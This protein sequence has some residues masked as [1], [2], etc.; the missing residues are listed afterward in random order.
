MII[1]PRKWLTWATFPD[2]SDLRWRFNWIYLQAACDKFLLLYVRQ[3]FTTKVVNLRLSPESIADSM[4]A[5]AR[6]QVR[7]ARKDALTISYHQDI[8]III[9]LFNLTA[10]AKGLIGVSK[11]TFTTK[12]R[13]LVSQIDAE[14]T[15]PLAAHF[16]LLDESGKRVYLSYN[17]SAYRKFSG[18]RLRSLCGRAN[19]LLFLED[20]YYFKSLGY[21]AYDF[22]GYDPDSTDPSRQ[23]VNIFKDDLPGEVVMQYNYYPLWY[24]LFKRAYNQIQKWRN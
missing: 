3:P 1:E 19:K 7:R 24:W 5:K 17:C 22:G 20:M 21:D 15:G 13:Y 12:Q 18:G 6:Y 2:C 8:K 9:E 23:S 14:G 11:K 10:Q 4:P 16:Y